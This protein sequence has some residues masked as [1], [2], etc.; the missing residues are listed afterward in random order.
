MMNKVRVTGKIILLLSFIIFFAQMSLRAYAYS[1]PNPYSNLYDANSSYLIATESGYERVYY[2]GDKVRMETYDKLFNRIG[3]KNF[4]LELELWG[5]FY[6]GTDA[7]YFV[8]G[9]KNYAQNNNAEVIRVIK[10]DKN[11]NRKGAAS[12]KSNPELAGGGVRLPFHWGSVQMTEKNSTLYVVTGHEGYL[13]GDGTGQQGL[14]MIAVNESNMTGNIVMAD[15]SHSF[16]QYIKTEGNDLFLLEQSEGNR[17]VSLKKITPSLGY[18]NYVSATVFPYGGSHSGAWDVECHASVED[19]AVSSNNIISVGTSVD[20]SRVSTIDTELNPY[21]IYLTVTPISSFN[22]NNPSTSKNTTVKWLTNHSGLAPSFRGV[23]ITKVNDDRFIVT[24]EECESYEASTADEDGLSNHTMHYTFIN[25][26]GEQIS[27]EFTGNGPWSFCHPIYDN[28]KLVYYASDEHMVNFYTVD[29]VTGEFKKTVIR[30][31][32][33]V[34][35]R[36]DPDGRQRFYRNGAISFEN[37][38]VTDGSDNWF[39]VKG[40]FLQSGY[41][42]LVQHTNGKWY[43]VQNGVLYWGVQTLVQYNGTWYYVNNSTVDWSYTGLAYYNGSWYLIQ[44]GQLNWGVKTLVQYNKT[45]YYVNNSTVDWNYTGLAYYNGSW[46]LIQKGQLNWGVKTLVQY[47]KVW[48]YVNNSTVDWKY[49]GLAYY[50]GSWY[51]IQKGQLNWGVKTLVLYNGV[52][53]YVNNSTVDWKYTGLTYYNGSWYLVQ[54]GQ[55]NWGVRTLILYNGN[56]YYVNNSTVDWKYTG[57]FEYKGTDYY[58]Q[59]GQINWGIN[60]LTYINGT[61]YLL[62][63]SALRGSYTGLVEYNKTLYYVQKGELIWGYN[64]IVSYEGRDYVVENSIAKEVFIPSAQVALEAEKVEKKESVP[65]SIIVESEEMEQIEESEQ[66]EKMETSEKN[67][68]P[69]DVLIDNSVLPEKNDHSEDI[70]EIEEF[71]MDECEHKEESEQEINVETMKPDADNHSEEDLSL[72]EG[73]FT[74]EKDSN[75]FIEECG[76]SAEENNNEAIEEPYVE[77]QLSYPDGHVE[78]EED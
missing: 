1:D 11:W 51:L 13:R 30:T 69:E 38:L 67:A 73:E 7:Y 50:N 61:W 64:G 49:T 16:A 45:W 52:W 14:L 66:I 36:K 8:E 42:G 78:V 72:E 29:G 47:N 41:T 44:K 74:E 55:L 39:Y 23:S 43:Y 27:G 68:Q 22:S 2:D 5:G 9:Q 12:I 28:G 15:L 31:N 33:F 46:Y 20:Q 37:G 60:G 62:S 26:S 76:N 65:S 71:S 32:G 63:N 25:G 77:G 58:I 10:Y 56:W 54:N 70:E 4:D 53:Y 57:L 24:W 3:G 18:N 19:L 40:G 48:Y 35:F 17:C 6:A 34:G 75:E 59:K 21:N